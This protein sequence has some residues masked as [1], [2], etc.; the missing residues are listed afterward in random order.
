MSTYVAGGKKGHRFGPFAFPV[1]FLLLCFFLIAL[2][3]TAA[4]AESGQSSSV[5]E[6]RLAQARLKYNE[7]TVHVY[8]R[9]R[10]RSVRGKFNVCFYESTIKPFIIINI[11]E[12]LQITDEAEMEAILEVVVKNEHYSEEE[13]G[14]ISFMKAQ[15]IAHNMAHSMASGSE[16]QQ[17]LV[18]TIAGESIQDVIGRAEELDLS[19]YG[20]MSSRHILLYQIIEF[21]FCTNE[22]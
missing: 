9:G 3:P 13:Y 16:E 4:A 2:L 10:G 17:W 22:N 11:K 21:V 19:P 6:E 18:E 7:D 12:S 15:W 14:T 20:S 1:F 5:W 8:F